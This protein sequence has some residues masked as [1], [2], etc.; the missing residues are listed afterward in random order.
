MQLPPAHTRVSFPRQK[1]PGLDCGI[2]APLVSGI[3][4]AERR[5][6]EL[7]RQPAGTN[8]LLREKSGSIPLRNDR[9][10]GKGRDDIYDFDEGLIS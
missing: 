2:R 6:V 10:H 7:L 3:S 8:N 9:Y 4:L 5:L 1:T